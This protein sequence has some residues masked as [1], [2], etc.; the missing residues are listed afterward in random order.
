MSITE[1]TGWSEAFD[2]F[3]NKNGL[4]SK[5]S[6]EISE[7]EAT[8]RTDFEAKARDDTCDPV[9]ADVTTFAVGPTTKVLDVFIEVSSLSITAGW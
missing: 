2:L 9:R 5:G 4:T 8:W 7:M 3:N 6:T 1:R